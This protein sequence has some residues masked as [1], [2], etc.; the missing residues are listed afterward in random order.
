MRY[1]RQ[2][3]RHVWTARSVEQVRA[4]G[5]RVL[6]VEEWKRGVHV[7]HC[8]REYEF[9]LVYVKREAVAS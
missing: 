8:T 6:W 3:D 5:W 9:R 2:G 7:L 1:E 4:D